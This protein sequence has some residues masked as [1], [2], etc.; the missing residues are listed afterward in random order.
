MQ[1]VFDE[2]HKIVLLLYPLQGGIVPL[3]E[4]C[5]VNF[6]PKLENAKAF[7]ECLEAWGTGYDTADRDV[8]ICGFFDVTD[9]R[10]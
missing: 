3:G 7:C 4:I 1:E 10:K 8:P 2:L 5:N 6:P 9:Q